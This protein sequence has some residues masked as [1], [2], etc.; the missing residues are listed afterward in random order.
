ML[1]QI[2]FLGGF[3][4]FN[5]R[6]RK[7]PLIS[8]MQIGQQVYVVSAL[9]RDSTSK[10]TF[11]FAESGNPNNTFNI[12]HYSGRITLAKELDHEMVSSY[13]LHLVANDSEHA[14]NGDLY[15]KVTDE[16][17]NPPKFSEPGYEVSFN[18]VEVL[19]YLLKAF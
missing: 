3:I 4:L 9:D 1:N 11:D 17:D 13:V 8:D 2:F 5:C 15:I 6:I 19:P 16:N 14:A 12:D 7:F 18:R 10:V